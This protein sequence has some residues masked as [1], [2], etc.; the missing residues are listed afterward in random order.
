MMRALGLALAI[1]LVLLAGAL[2]AL[3]W[4]PA[5]L[6]RVGLDAAGIAA[7]RFED[8]RLGP[9][10]LEL[11]G[12]ELG[13]PPEHRLARLQIRYRLRDLLHG[14]VARVEIEGLELHG[15]LT[16]G[17]IELPGL[18]LPNDGAEGAG[19]PILPWPQEIVL[20]G[21]KIQLATPWGLLRAPLAA[22]LRPAPPDAA[23]RL[24]VGGGEL[25]GPAGRLRAA[26]SLEGHLPL[27]RTLALQD[28]AAGGRVQLAAEGFSLTGVADGID[29]MAEISL[30]LADGR[31]DARMT[32]GELRVAELAA[33]LAALRAPLPPPW[34]LALADP[35]RPLQARGALAGDI[36]SLDLDGALRLAAGAATVA[37]DLTGRVASDA[38]AA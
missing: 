20:R 9:G 31:L 3:L 22:E 24:E 37:L 17:R 15:R 6:L 32:S 19:W 14:A 11:R 10:A 18:D 16:D 1:L 8:L 27:D 13:Q 33:A 23:F 7:V 25:I 26:L 34:R 28:V 35:A 29:G 21:A 2:A 30:A 4:F 5:A 36:L 12:L 38:P